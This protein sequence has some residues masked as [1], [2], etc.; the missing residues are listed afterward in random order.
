MLFLIFFPEEVVE[1]LVQCFAELDAEVDGGVVVALFD[2]GDG[3]A[4]HTDDVSELLLGVVL[5]RASGLDFEVLHVD[6][7]PLFV[8]GL[9]CPVF[10]LRLCLPVPHALHQGGDERREERQCDRRIDN[11]VRQDPVLNEVVRIDV[12]ARRQEIGENGDAIDDEERLHGRGLR[13]LCATQRAVYG[14]HRNAQEHTEED[15]DAI[16]H[17]SMAAE[18]CIQKIQGSVNTDGIKA[19]LEGV[20]SDE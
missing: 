8:A 4:G 12:D 15:C 11:G 7:L 18:A 13:K 2:G 16:L 17:E 1:S 5:R 10:V 20:A 9:L 6:R 3:L 14:K 19:V